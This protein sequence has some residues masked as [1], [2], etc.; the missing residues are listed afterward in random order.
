MGL[1]LITVVVLCF[2][3]LISAIAGGFYYMNS[4]NN[5]SND[6]NNDSNSGSNDGSSNGSNGNT[7]GSNGSSNDGSNGNTNGG[8]NGGTNDNSNGGTNNGGSNNSSDNYNSDSIV[9]MYENNR[10]GNP[11]IVDGNSDIKNGEFKAG[12]Y[13]ITAD[14]MRVRSID[15]PSDLKVT[16][17]SDTN[18]TTELPNVITESVELGYCC[19]DTFDNFQSFKI[20]VK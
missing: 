12:A 19:L 14:Q 3:I 2:C 6:S 20:T 11:V 7:N 8:S 10:Y 16:F 17:Y 1:I 18:F 4:N 15:L 13:N 9:T 5:S